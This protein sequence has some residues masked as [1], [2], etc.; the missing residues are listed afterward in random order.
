M[1]KEDIRRDMGN[2]V[3]TRPILSFGCIAPLKQWIDQHLQAYH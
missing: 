3:C 1:S 2:P